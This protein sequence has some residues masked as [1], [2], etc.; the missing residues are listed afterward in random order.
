MKLKSNQILY[1]TRKY[2][3]LKQKK[4][5][6]HGHAPMAS[7][8]SNSPLEHVCIDFFHLETSHGDFENILVVVD[9]FTRFAQ[10]C[11]IRNKAGKNAADHLF[12]DFIPRFGYPTKLHLDHDREFENELFR[13]LRRLSRAGHSRTTPITHKT[14]LTI[15]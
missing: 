7:I 6:T 10:A 3:C 13:V 11:P 4:P 9:H 2:L 5:S 8:T 14:T 15:V 1:V 12:N